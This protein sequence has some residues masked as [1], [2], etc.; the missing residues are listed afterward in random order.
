MCLLQMALDAEENNLK[1]AVTRHLAFMP[2]A[3]FGNCIPIEMNLFLKEGNNINP[4]IGNAVAVGVM[5]SF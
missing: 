2:D 1:I 3:G 4:L 5:L